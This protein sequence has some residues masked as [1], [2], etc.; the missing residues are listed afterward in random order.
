VSV[1][2]DVLLPRRIVHIFRRATASFISLIQGN[3]DFER[4]LILF[5]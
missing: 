5:L 4:E 3:L 2:E 1:R